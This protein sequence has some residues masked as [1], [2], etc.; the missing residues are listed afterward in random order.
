MRS[1]GDLWRAVRWPLLVLAVGGVGFGVATALDRTPALAGSAL[2]ELSLPIGAPSL[3]ILLP[4]GLV[5]LVVAVIMYVL[6]SRRG[7]G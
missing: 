7:G 6:K 4:G 2:R 1:D 5:W 3:F